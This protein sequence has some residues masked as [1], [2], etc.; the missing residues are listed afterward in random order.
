[1]QRDLCAAALLLVMLGCLL[2]GCLSPPAGEENRSVQLQVYTEEFPPYNFRGPDGAVTGSSTDVVREISNRLGQEATIGLSSWSDGYSRTLSTPDTALYSTARTVEREHLFSWVGPIGSF[3]YVFYARNGTALPAASLEAVKRAGTI[4]VVR[5]DARHQ[6]LVSRNVTDLALYPDDESC[7]RALMA[8]E[9]DLWLGSSASV[10]RTIAAAG[11]SPG[12]VVPVYV[13]S[14]TELFIAFNNQTSPKVIAAWQDTLDAMKRDGTFDAI[15]ARY[16]LPVGPHTAGSSGEN[17]RLVLSAIMTLADQR[18]SG[19]AD[20][21]EVLA[22]T[23][24]ARSGDWER[25]RPLLL[26]LE[27]RTSGAR[28]WYALPD[29]SYY[30]T[31]DNLTTAS[32]AS[33]PYFPVVLGGN[34]SIGSVVVSHSTGRTTGIVAVPIVKGGKVSGVLGG[35]VYLDTLSNDLAR[36]LALPPGLSFFALDR[37]GTFALNSQTSRI[38]QQPAVQGTPSETG[39]FRSI[40]SQE[41]GEVSYVSEGMQQT[42]VF[43]TSPITGWRFG[44]GVVD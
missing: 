17:S 27:E 30:T 4:A 31:V 24:D 42:V 14:S 15:L 28:L 3:D 25:I 1:M 13:A 44:V 16:G 34:T 36:A 32:L 26:A 19:L 39:A 43:R 37:N 29:G 9:C 2:S 6:Y 41:S 11:Y 20:S 18:L 35:S 22:L 21:L 12:D 5:D 38:G 10:S 7:L 33:R 23:G 40:L 8:G